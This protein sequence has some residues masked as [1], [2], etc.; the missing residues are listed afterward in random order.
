M[1]ST[2]RIYFHHRLYSLVEPRHIQGWNSEIT[3]GKITINHLNRLYS[4]YHQLGLGGGGG[5]FPIYLS[6]LKKLFF[7]T[8][9][10]EECG[11]ERC[12]GVSV[13]LLEQD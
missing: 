2:V 10:L 5:V 13:H 8:S 4:S 11:H 7:M 6:V 12:G 1:P 3:A 9:N